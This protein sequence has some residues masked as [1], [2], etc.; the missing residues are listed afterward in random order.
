MLLGKFL[1]S[2]WRLIY[3][4][5]LGFTVFYAVVLIVAEPSAE[6]DT[7]IYTPIIVR[8][9]LWQ[10]ILVQAV[11]LVIGTAVYC[12]SRDEWD[13]G[14]TMIAVPLIISGIL[15]T[16]IAQPAIGD[17]RLF[18]ESSVRV[19]AHVYNLAHYQLG[20][21]AIYECDSLGIVCHTL[22]RQRGIISLE[23]K[24]ECL[25]PPRWETIEDTVSLIIECKTL[26][27]HHVP[28]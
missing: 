23:H 11:F 16:S 1:T 2:H 5:G 26:F 21:L 24:E 9:M 6:A 19:K 28:D 7:I 25:G 18:H 13:V 17:Q 12:S 3:G 27:T 14:L 8:A 22:F 15:T 4:I 20:Q 10:L